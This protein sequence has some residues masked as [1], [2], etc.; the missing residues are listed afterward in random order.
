MSFRQL[1]DRSISC[2]FRKL[3]LC[4]NKILIASKVLI[5]Q[6]RK[7]TSLSPRNNETLRNLICE[8]HKKFK[9]QDKYL[10]SSFKHHID[11]I[12]RL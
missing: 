6:T 11:T 12:Y 2:V 3:E 1:R 7:F 10:Q 9:P 8:A 5:K 4:S